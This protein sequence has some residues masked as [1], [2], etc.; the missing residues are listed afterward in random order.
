MSRILCLMLLAAAIGCKS[1]CR[2]WAEG[3]GACPR[4]PPGSQMREACVKNFEQRCERL[5]D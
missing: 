2:E 1:E 5:R 3:Q 4:M